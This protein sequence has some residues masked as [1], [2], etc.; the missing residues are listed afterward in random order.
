MIR[1]AD[2]DAAI[3]ELA[4]AGFLAPTAEAAELS[5]AADGDEDQLRAF[6]QRRTSGEPLAWI[7]GTTVFCGETILVHP[8][9]YVPRPQTQAMAEA[10]VARLP[11][12]G[13]AVD[14][15]TGSGA[16]AVV[17]S[18]RQ[19]SAQVMATDLDP[20]AVAC[21]RANGVDAHQGDLAQPLPPEM[22]GRADVVTAVVPYVPTESLHLL[23]RDVRA[24]EPTAAL[25]GGPGGTEVLDR[26]V[27]AASRILSPGGWLLLELGGNQP[28]HLE[29]SLR[30]RAFDRIEVRTDEEGDPRS[31]EARLRAPG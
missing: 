6:V 21:A 2:I 3:D 23:Q 10:A 30:A 17:L 14:L 5:A 31:I 16:I 9:V 11:P 13:T 20:A 4:R 27:E 28:A 15:C 1:P 24:H 7:T 25:D 18:R 26:A 8:G 19:P 29:P 12:G 22:T